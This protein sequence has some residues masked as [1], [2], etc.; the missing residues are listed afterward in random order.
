[1]K[2]DK[3]PQHP[4]LIRFSRREHMIH[5]IQ[6]GAGTDL[7]LLRDNNEDSYL[8]VDAPAPDCDTLRYGRLYVVADGMGGHAAGEVA[9]RK[10]CDAM[11]YYYLSGAGNEDRSP[12]APETVLKRLAGAIRETNRSIYRFAREH[13]THRGMGTTLSALVILEGTALIGHVGDSRIYRLREG[14]LEQLTVDHTEVQSMVD[15]GYLSREAAARHPFRHVLL[16][17]VGVSETLENLYTRAEKVIPGD[18][19]LLS[20]D[21]L[22]DMIP[23]SMIQVLLSESSDAQTACRGLIQQALDAGG[24][25]NVTAVV[26]RIMSEQLSANE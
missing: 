9:S 21:G 22:H 24:R 26:V 10:A 7:G 5:E 11:R 20:S 1:M 12:L 19:F 25:D 17:A 23:D 2:Q 18:I 6:I 4:I 16:Q 8:I 13:P 3:D 15:K 14:M